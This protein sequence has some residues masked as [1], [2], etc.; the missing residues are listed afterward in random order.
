MP[1][2][3]CALRDGRHEVLA[4]KIVIVLC[5]M[6]KEKGAEALKILTGL[7]CGWC[8]LGASVTIANAS[9][10]VW[11][12][13]TLNFT[14][15][16]GTV[17]GVFTYDADTNAYSAWSIDVSGFSDPVMNGLLTPATSSVASFASSGSFDLSYSSG[18][19]AFEAVFGYNS[20]FNFI[21]VPLTDSGGDVPGMSFVLLDVPNYTSF[22]TGPLPVVAFTTPEPMSAVLV[23]LG[24]L[25]L[26][27][28]CKMRMR[29]RTSHR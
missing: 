17:S 22:N 5:S 29:R 15:G 6:L 1:R 12:I 25:S 26:S 24:G 19:S 16:G 2:G 28:F 9:P 4:V 23:V 11:E 20:G 13:P 8:L 7:I 14:T 21:S 27:V 18:Q 3:E 10:L